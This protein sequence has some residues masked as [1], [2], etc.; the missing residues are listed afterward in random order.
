[1][2]QSTSRNIPEAIID[3]Q[4]SV[5]ALDK[6]LAL[7]NEFEDDQ[8][9]LWRG[10][11]AYNKARVLRRLSDHDTTVGLE[12]MEAFQE[13]IRFRHKWT[14][15]PVVLPNVV[16]VGLFT[17]YLHAKAARIEMRQSDEAGDFAVNDEFVTEARKEFEEW[18][19]G[20]D[21]NRVRLARNV[22]ETWTK[23]KAKNSRPI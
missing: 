10:Y 17:E 3:W 18:L 6:V 16:K 4:Q 21:Q 14:Q 13:A 2:K 1:M 8:L 12:W 20:P 5:G 22:M 7:A 19:A 9:P 11:A 23:I 15:T